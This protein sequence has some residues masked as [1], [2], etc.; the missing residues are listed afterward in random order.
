MST[1]GQ[2]RPFLFS[3]H[4][5]VPQCI[6][7]IGENEVH[8]GYPPRLFVFQS[9]TTNKRKT[10]LFF[11]S[12]EAKRALKKKVLCL[13]CTNLHRPSINLPIHQI[14]MCLAGPTISLQ[15]RGK[16]TPWT[17]FRTVVYW[18]LFS[19]TTLTPTHYTATDLI[20]PLILQFPFSGS[21]KSSIHLLNRMQNPPAS[22]ISGT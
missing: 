22:G 20:L 2:F 13:A 10:W 16:K 15:T 21:S 11:V 12:T 6:V 5:G 9:Y 14:R 1:T 4:Y 8:S 18:T 7:A 3:V 19:L 17:W